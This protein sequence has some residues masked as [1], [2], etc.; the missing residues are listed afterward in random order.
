MDYS[1]LLVI[2]ESKNERISS[3]YFKNRPTFDKN[4]KHI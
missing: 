1:L 3:Q 4:L 2:E